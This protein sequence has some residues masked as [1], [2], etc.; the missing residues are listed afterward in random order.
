MSIYGTT[1]AL[2]FLD[3]SDDMSLHNLSFGTT[4]R[5][6]LQGSWTGED[7]TDI[8]AIFALEDGTDTLS[9]NIGKELPLLAL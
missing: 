6:Y 7:G 4:Y 1:S 8:L 2:G 5:S 9:R 3:E